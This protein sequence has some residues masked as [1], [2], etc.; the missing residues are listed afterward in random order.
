MFKIYKSNGVLLPTELT[1]TETFEEAW[2]YV[3]TNYK[4]LYGEKDEAHDG[5]AD[6]YVKLPGGGT[7]ILGIEPVDFKIEK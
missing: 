5:C 1:R 3:E 6:F 2:A 7:A 4:I